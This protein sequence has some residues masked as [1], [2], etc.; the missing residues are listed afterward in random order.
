MQKVIFRKIEVKI[1][2]SFK[3][4]EMVNKKCVFILLPLLF[5][6]CGEKKVEEKKNPNPNPVSWNKPI[7]PAQNLNDIEIDIGK[8][9]CLSFSEMKINLQDSFGGRRSLNLSMKEKSCSII[10]ESDY[11]TSADIV[12][13]RGTGIQM[14]GSRSGKVIEDVL[15]DTHSRLN[16]FCSALTN[17]ADTEEGEGI[18]N[19]VQ[20]GALRYQVN[21]FQASGYDW[22]QIVDFKVRGNDY[23]PF[24]TD[25]AAIITSFNTTAKPI[26]Y[27]FSLSRTIAKPC[28]DLTTS[29]LSQFID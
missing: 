28:A 4:D 18:S 23:F 2:K 24:L 5:S 15:T 27:G 22:V 26:N 19:T 10:G 21:F 6:S 29:Y 1:I 20:E 13:I 17:E 3:D 11:K 25:R 7:G 8:R 14:E 12:L 9:V 16:K